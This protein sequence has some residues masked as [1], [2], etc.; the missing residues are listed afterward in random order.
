[1]AGEPDDEP[2]DLGVAAT[3]RR[4]PVPP[5]HQQRDRGIE[6]TLLGVLVRQQPFDDNLVRGPDLRPRRRGQPAGQRVCRVPHR[7]SGVGQTDVLGAKPLDET[8]G[9]ARSALP[10][11]STSP[12]GS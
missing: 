6:L 9:V 12:G 10:I 2:L 7:R 8:T 4:D 1:M 11:A 5:A 3:H